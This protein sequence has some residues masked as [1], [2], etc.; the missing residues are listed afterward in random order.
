MTAV[1][2]RTVKVCGYKLD[3]NNTFLSVNNIQNLLYHINADNSSI[4][5]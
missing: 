1:E 4:T 2:Q 3:Y 5:F